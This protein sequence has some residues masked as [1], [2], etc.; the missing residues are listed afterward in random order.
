[1]RRRFIIA[2][3]VG[4]SLAAGIHL[5][6]AVT[7]EIG[8]THG[9]FFAAAGV[10][11]IVLAVG[12]ARSTTRVRLVV[13][14]LSSVLLLAV[15]FAERVGPDAADG[16]GVLDSFASASEL[17][18]AV[19]AAS[20]LLV[21]ATRRSRSMSLRGPVALAA[22]AASLSLAAAPAEHDHHDQPVAP[23]A[24][25]DAAESPLDPGVGTRAPSTVAPVAPALT[26]D[27]VTGEA[28]EH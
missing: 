28:H 2:A 18:V 26:D 8:T 11:Q 6:V 12:I 5:A 14:A 20:V 9:A 25:T 16:P 21:G 15:W 17:V 22:V 10:V 4:L 3:T 19:S 7:H 23:A 24:V 27:H 13:A 1:M